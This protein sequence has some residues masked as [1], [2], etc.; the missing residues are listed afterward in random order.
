M[1]SLLTGEGCPTTW[2][3]CKVEEARQ[4]CVTG[5]RGLVMR[6]MRSPRRRI[7]SGAIEELTQVSAQLGL[8]ASNVSLSEYQCP[9]AYL[10]DVFDTNF[11]GPLNITRALLPKLRAKNKGTLLYISSQAG[12]EPGDAEK[13]VS[14]LIDLVKGLV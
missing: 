13:A 14:V 3:K 6:R 2:F 4:G 10:K 1:T 9:R 11:H 7:L 5:Y 8:L 12:N